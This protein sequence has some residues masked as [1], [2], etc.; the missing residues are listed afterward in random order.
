MR[1]F[2]HFIRFIVSSDVVASADLPSLGLGL[3][4][5]KR[6]AGR[7]DVGFRTKQASAES[8]IPL[9]LR[10]RR[11]K[12]AS[13]TLKMRRISWLRGTSTP[14]CKEKATCTVS[15]VTRQTSGRAGEKGEAV[16]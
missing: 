15:L 7:S 1:D 14:L 8:L 11:K 4:R 13:K 16:K 6:I 12:K 5:H 2:A 9:D 3:F 10:S